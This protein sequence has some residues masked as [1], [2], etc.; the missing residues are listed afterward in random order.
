MEY[1]FESS[2][3]NNN[4]INNRKRPRFLLCRPDSSYS[5]LN[6]LVTFTK[7]DEIEDPNAPNY[8]NNEEASNST[9]KAQLSFQRRG[10]THVPK[11]NSSSL[12]CNQNS[13][14]TSLSKS[15]SSLQELKSILITKKKKRKEGQSQFQ[16]IY[17]FNDEHEDPYV[18]NAKAGCIIST[19]TP[20]K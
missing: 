6:D 14:I 17:D 11:S 5:P 18:S 20:K 4:S 16:S 9:E 1:K 3:I 8:P 2:N 12:Y 15:P 19:D 13:V 10:Q 7:E